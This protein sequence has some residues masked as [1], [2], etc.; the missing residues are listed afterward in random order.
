MER[1]VQSEEASGKAV[2]IGD[3]APYLVA[4]KI[5][6]LDPMLDSADFFE[7]SACRTNAC[8]VV[9]V[10]RLTGHLHNA[11]FILD[12]DDAIKTRLSYNL[13]HSCKINFRFVS[14]S[15]ELV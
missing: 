4:G 15:I 6:I 12:S 13:K 14:G 5:P 1:P 3:E 2:Y 10:P 8:R 11:S 7:Q 9:K